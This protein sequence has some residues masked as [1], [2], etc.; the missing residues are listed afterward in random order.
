LGVDA[1]AQLRSVLVAQ[2]LEYRC[3]VHILQWLLLQRSVIESQVSSS[4]ELLRVRPFGHFC[5]CRLSIGAHYLYNCC[6][7]L[8]CRCS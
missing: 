4:G 5:S 2:Q 7:Q 3:Q 8:P 1:F 6:P